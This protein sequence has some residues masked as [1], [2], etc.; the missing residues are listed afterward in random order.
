MSL[1]QAIVSMVAA[2]VNGLRLIWPFSRPISCVS[3]KT[4]PM[5]PG[6]IRRRFASIG[7]VPAGRAA[8]VLAIR[9]GG[10]TA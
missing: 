3:G 6:G 8:V 9:F 10:G 2:R 4:A 1:D 5:G 7:G